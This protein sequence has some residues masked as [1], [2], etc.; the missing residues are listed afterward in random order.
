MTTVDLQY[1]FNMEGLF[2]GGEATT[3]SIGLINAF[4]KR[5][6]FVPTNGGFES[7]THDPRGRLAYVRLSAGF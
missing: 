4:D 2:D 1:N 6:P 3:F 7:R 5:P